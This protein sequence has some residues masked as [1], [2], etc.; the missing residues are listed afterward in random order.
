MQSFI[1]FHRVVQEKQM[2]R[3]KRDILNYLHTDQPSHRI[4]Y[5]LIKNLY[6][7]VFAEYYLSH[8]PGIMHE[9][10]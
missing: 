3:A 9:L 10:L 8:I 7:S 4:S 1:K 2:K 6:S 5:K